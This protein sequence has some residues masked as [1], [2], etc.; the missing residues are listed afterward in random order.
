MNKFL[1]ALLLSIA[2]ASSAE[3]Q[4]YPM[5]GGDAN[6]DG[7]VDITDSV[8]ILSYLFGGGNPPVS[9]ATELVPNTFDLLDLDPNSRFVDNLDGTT[10]DLFT[11]LQWNHTV[12]QGLH[13]KQ[14]TA[15]GGIQPIETVLAD[16]NANDAYGDW[17]IVS[18][19]EYRAAYPYYELGKWNDFNTNFQS[20]H[21]DTYINTNSLP[22]I[23]N[24]VMGQSINPIH[25]AIYEEIEFAGCCAGSSRTF[26]FLESYTVDPADP[27]FAGQVWAYSVNASKNAGA[28]NRSFSV[29]SGGGDINY[30]VSVPSV[31]NIA[32]SNTRPWYF[33]V[34]KAN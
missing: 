24:S 1:T 11:G 32:T 28:F 9:V 3:A 29:G 20:P 31:G 26:Y 21:T 5:N 13:P 10:T 27:N 19:Q 7:V 14:T 6:G 30:T 16:F 33:I 34:R 8:H 17:R 2:T 12:L 23:F 18:L 25:R 22:F 15:P 4:I